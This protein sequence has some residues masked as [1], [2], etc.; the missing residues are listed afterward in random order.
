[1]GSNPPY[2]HE[3]LGCFLEGCK[4]EFEG[5][6]GENLKF[7]PRGGGIFVPATVKYGFG[8]SLFLS[9]MCGVLVGPCVVA[10]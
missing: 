9:P 10:H 5:L 3:L 4:A 8:S 7:D 2:L 1:M 6:K